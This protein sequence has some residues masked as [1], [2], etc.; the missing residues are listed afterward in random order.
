MSD[1]KKALDANEIRKFTNELTYRRYLM[2][3]GKIQELFCKITLQEY[4]ALYTITSEREKSSNNKG[5]TYLKD[6]SQKME[7]TMRQT[8]KMVEKLKDRGLVLWSYDGTGS[9]GT[10]V[11]VTQTGEKLFQ[12][13]EMILRECYGN[14]IKKFGKENLILLLKMMKQLDNLICSEIKEM[15]E[16]DLHGR[17][18]EMDE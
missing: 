18:D 7:L 12:E 6:L 15:G 4:I 13:Q 8:S 2:N 11:I 16:D 9:E 10:Y 17:D 1:Q 5:R 3:K 14:V